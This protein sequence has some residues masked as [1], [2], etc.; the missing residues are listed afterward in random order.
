MRPYITLVSEPD[1]SR[2]GS[3]SE[4]N[5]THDVCPVFL[6]IGP[7]GSRAIASRPCRPVLNAHAYPLTILSI[8]ANDWKR[9][10]VQHSPHWERT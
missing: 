5:I 3:G 7:A 4:T 6:V 10:G 9:G 8:I 1:P 2:E